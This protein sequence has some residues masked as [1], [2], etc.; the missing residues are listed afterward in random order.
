MNN[1]SS[2]LVASIFLL[3]APLAV[4]AHSP[5]YIGTSN[6]ETIP[7][8]NTSRAY[9]GELIGKPAEFDITLLSTTTFYISIL[10]PDVA[11]ARSDFAVRMLSAT[12]DTVLTL[13][14]KSPWEKWYEEFAGDWYLKGPE[15]RRALAAGTYTII[16]SNPENQGKYVLA[17]GE[18]EVFTVAGIP[19][20]IAEIYHV[21]TE[22]FGK[23]RY[24]IFEGIIG[25]VL[26]G[27]SFALVL[28]VSYVAYRIS[29]RRN[30][31]TFGAS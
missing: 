2:I 20:T 1:N 14:Q 11:G 18:A 25:K 12:G 17:P 7:D 21:K 6:I 24:S 4:S 23:P 3:M 22:F 15:M 10:A 30:N 27:L 5:S 31:S 26:F 28:T 8:A 16:V 13:E 19:K 9:Y 29:S